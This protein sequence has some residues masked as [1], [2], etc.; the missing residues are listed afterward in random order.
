VSYAGLKDRNAVTTQWYSVQLPGRPDPDWA[1]LNSEHLKINQVVRHN[2][3]LKRGA[4]SANHFEIHLR[5]LQGERTEWQSRLEQISDTGV[6]NYFGKQRFGHQMNNLARASDLIKNNKLRRLKPHKRGIYLSAMRSWLFNSMVSERLQLANYETP[7]SGDVMM[8]A[9]SNACFAEEV[10]TQLKARVAD[11]EL[12][13]TAAMWGRGHSMA[14]AAVAEL[15]QKIAD[16]NREFA[17]A[18]EQAG[19]KQ[20]RRAMRLLP[21]NMQWQFEADNSLIVSFD[22]TKGSYATAVLRELGDIHDKSLP[23]FK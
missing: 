20:E 3:K 21:V 17:S 23:E 10:D 14:S 2:R 8:L 18:L 1:Q 6:P 22:L 15:E 4:L 9:A 13:L 7:L 5:Q 11:K 12:H 19:M 16:D